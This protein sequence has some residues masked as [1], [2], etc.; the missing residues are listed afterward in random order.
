[1]RALSRRLTASCLHG[2]L[3]AAVAFC[4]MAGTRVRAAEGE[5]GA[6]P[7]LPVDLALVPHDTM[8][9]L[10]MNVGTHWSGPEKASLEEISHAHPIVL[11]HDALGLEQAFGLAPADIDRILVAVPR[12]GEWVAVFTTAQPFDRDKLFKKIVPAGEEKPIGGKSYFAAETAPLAVSFVDP[13]TFIL[14]TRSGLKTFLERPAPADSAAAARPAFDAIDKKAILAV[15]VMPGMFPDEAKKQIPADAPWRPLFDAKSVRMTAEAR[16]GLRIHLRAEFDSEDAAKKGAVLFDEIPKRLDAF[17]G[18]AEEHLPAF[19]DK[20][21]E[22]FKDAKKL[23]ARMDG[24][25]KA[26]R[27]GLKGVAATQKGNVVSLD[28]AVDTKKPATTAVLLLSLVP[29]A[30]K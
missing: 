15:D 24:A 14:S 1:M 7:K 23:G 10:S 4:C 21:Q 29:R 8:V 22:Q 3:L 25:I 26:G 27:A 9:L 11:T 20:Q 13:R 18:I 19:F 6:Q 2:A 28:I 30:R 5:D 16:D 12:G 17:F